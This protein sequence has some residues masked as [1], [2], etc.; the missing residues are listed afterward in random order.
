VHREERVNAAV[1]LKKTRF[2]LVLVGRS[3]L[4]LARFVHA[5]TV[6]MTLPAPAS[7]MQDAD[8]D[9]DVVVG[10]FTH[11]AEAFNRSPG[12]RSADTLGR[13]I[14]SIPSAR[15]ESW[16]DAA[17]GPGLVSRALARRV[18]A[19]HGIDLTPAMVALAKREARR[20][21]ISNAT[22][23]LGDAT[24]LEF[25]DESFDG[26]VS[27]FSLH[28][29]PVPGRAIVEFARVVRP[30]GAVV[31]AD[32][33]T[34]DD[35]EI[36]AR[37]QEI[38]RLRDPSHW[39][40]LTKDRLLTLGEDAGL[41]LEQSDQYS[42]WI[43]FQEWLERGSGGLAARNLI[44]QAVAERSLAPVFALDPDGARVQFVCGLAIWRRRPAA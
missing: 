36:A 5:E 3:P 9:S 29:I 40:C 30:G 12:H 21:G 20:E 7:S 16:L 23:S 43:D 28:H 19:I 37:H 22:F 17:C 33:L 27:R 38:E 10:E 6:P 34:S 14:E 35:A 44:A 26:V 31:V 8:V 13:L 42:F 25:G 2:G 39:A 32:Q 1:V 18:G 41:K 4:S 15:H 24:S 11:Q